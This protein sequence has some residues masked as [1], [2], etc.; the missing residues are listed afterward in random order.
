MLLP[1]PNYLAT[2]DTTGCTRQMAITAA[3]LPE[4]ELDLM[5]VGWQV[6][7]NRELE[8]TLYVCPRC[9][10]QPRTRRVSAKPDPTLAFLDAPPTPSKTEAAQTE[11]RGRLEEA[12]DDW[13]SRSY[14]QGN[15]YTSINENRRAETVSTME[16]LMEKF[17]KFG[18]WTPRQ[19]AFVKKLIRNTFK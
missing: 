1:Q 10:V 16:D 19:E 7:T 5:S 9:A 3:T 6:F 8:E 15:E 11:L 17:D 2:C 4:A 14:H 18:R 12:R 13:S